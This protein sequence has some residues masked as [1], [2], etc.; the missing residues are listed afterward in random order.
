MLG[1]KQMIKEM[2][3]LGQISLPS[4]SW[5]LHFGVR[6]CEACGYDGERSAGV[7]LSAGP[8]GLDQWFSTLTVLESPGR[9]YYF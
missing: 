4:E 2:S 1:R 9:T 3:S 6:S 7:F 5:M 8:L